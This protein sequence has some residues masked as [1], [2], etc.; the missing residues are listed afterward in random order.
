MNSEEKNGAEASSPLERSQEQ[1]ERIIERIF[2]PTRPG[3]VFGEPVR[4][5]DYTLITASAVGSGGGF[6]FGGGSSP[7]PGTEGNSGGENAGAGG[8]GGGG[9][10]GRPVAVIIIGPDGV[11]V[12]PIVDV[13]Q[14]ALNGIKMAAGMIS[15]V[16]SMAKRQGKKR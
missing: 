9:A 11:R 10:S 3:A 4:S 13:T 7:M 12:E 6:G 8:G 5:G 15:F 14:V 16:T 2:A 1:A